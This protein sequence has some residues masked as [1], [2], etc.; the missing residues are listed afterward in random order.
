MNVL[1]LGGT[2][3][4]GSDLLEILT[5]DKRIGKIDLLSRRELDL[6][7][8]KVTNH[9]VDFSNLT[10]LPVHHR[11]DVLFIAF[12]TTLKKAGSQNKQWEIDVDIPT[13][14]M[15]LAKKYGINK[16]V[17]ISSVGVGLNSPFF[18]GRMKARLDE[19][20]KKI[21]FEQLIILKPS[22]LVG[23]RFEKRQVE[24]WSIAIGNLIGRT[25][26]ID[27]YK[28]VESMNVAKCM[29][30]AVFE[31]PKG[32]HEIISDDIDDFAS[33]YTPQKFDK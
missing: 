16:C 30:Q 11:I 15:D 33:R 4:V 18:Y 27:K 8:M 13:E 3:L 12:G 9:V 1:I 20:A 29:I 14:V 2:G 21:G 32:V 23:P 22:V 10:E 25:G 26:L 17:L 24:S 19:N 6:R 7:D 5:D 31:L 28:P